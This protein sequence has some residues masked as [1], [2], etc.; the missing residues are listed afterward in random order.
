MV[1]AWDM[2]VVQFGSGRKWFRHYTEFFSTEGNN[3]WKIAHEGL[4]NASKWSDAIDSWQ[5]PYVNDDSN[6]SGI[7]AC[8]STK[9]TSWLTV[10][11][12]GTSGRRDSKNSRHLHLH[13]CYDY[14][15]SA[16]WTF[17]SMLHAADKILA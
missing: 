7:A 10:D 12:S 3:A 9:C 17:A 15:Y 14:P 1:I 5:A 2:P 4:L 11:R 8:C 6:R 13:G 16:R